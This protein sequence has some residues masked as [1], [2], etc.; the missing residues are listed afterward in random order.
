[1]TWQARSAGKKFAGQKLLAALAQPVHVL[2][3]AITSCA[4]ETTVRG[5]LISNLKE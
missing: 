5:L 4:V 2:P 1:M 3:T